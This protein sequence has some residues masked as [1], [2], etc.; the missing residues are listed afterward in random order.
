MRELG[1][2]TNA[3]HSRLRTGRA[4]IGVEL[5]N[6]QSVM[7]SFAHSEY[8]GPRSATDSRKYRSR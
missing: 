2:A 1:A 6:A 5:S 3:S 8:H 4:G 7:L